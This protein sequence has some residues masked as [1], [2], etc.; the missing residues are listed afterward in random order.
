MKYFIHRRNTFSFLFVT[1]LLTVAFSAVD[2]HAIS[3][4]LENLS[5]TQIGW[6]YFSLG[7]THILPKGYDH[8]LFILGLYLLSPKLTDI[9]W[10][11][12]TFTIAHTL[13]L[14]LAM[15]GIIHPISGIIEPLIA[16]SIVFVGIENVLLKELRWWRI[17]IVFCFGLLHGCGF[18]GA[19]Q[20]IGLPQSGF[21][22]ALLSFNI[23]V[24]LGQIAII[25]LAYML[26]VKHF[27]EKVW[28]RARIVEPVS[29][30]IAVVAT[31]WAIERM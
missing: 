17:G 29:L 15:T 30:G 25:L 21:A 18:A 13:T 9:L 26:C 22:F 19:L 23:G 6:T 20:E 31:F 2:A 10:Q 7:F 5:R 11:A 8:V 12:T 1:L 4:D 24:E 16:I 14:G 3:A 27:S 28:Y